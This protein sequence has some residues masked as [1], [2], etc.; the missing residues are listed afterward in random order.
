MDVTAVLDSTKCFHCGQACADDTLWLQGRPFCCYG[1]KTVFEILDSNNLCEYYRLD[2]NPGVQL[3]EISDD[4]YAH[5]DE[6]DIRKRILTFDSAQFAKVSF[7]VP[8]IHC[9]SC[10]WL[11]ENLRKLNAGILHAEVNFSRKTVRVDFNPQRIKLSGVAQLMAS[12]GYAPKI[13]LKEAEDAKHKIDNTLILKVAIAGFCFGN[14]MLFSFPEYLG[15]DHAEKDLIRMFSWLNLALAVPALF[16]CG[17]DYLKSA[18]KSF[19]QKQINIDAPIAA[20]FIALFFRSAY[21]IVTA[22]GPGYLDSFTGL[23]FFLLIG[24]WFQSRTYESLAF[25][26]DFT[27]YFPLAVNRLEKD[28]WKP[29]VI[30]KLRPNDQIRIRNMELVP[31]DSI[32]LN[33]YAYIDYSFVT[34]ESRPVKVKQSEVAYAG[35]RLIGAPVTLIVEKSTSQSHLTSLWNNDAFRKI[36][37]SNYQKIIDRAA[38]KFTWFVLGIALITGIYWQV[39]APASMWLVLTS[40]LMVACPCAL[41]LAAPFTLGSM[42][43]VMGKNQLYL[44]NADV[45]ER[46]ASIDTIIFDKT[47]TITHGNDPEI[48]WTGEFREADLDGI[49]RLTSFSTHPLSLM[50]TRCIGRK[51][52]LLVTDFKELPGKGIHG[53]IDNRAFK[54]GSAAFAGFPEQINDVASHV[55]VSIDGKCCGYFTIKTAIRNNFREMLT[56]LGNKCHGLLSGDHDKDKAEMKYIFPPAAQLLFEQ[57]PQQKLDYIRHLQQQGRKV[58]MI[59]DGLNDAGALKQ[60]DVGIAVTDDTGIFTPAC[61]GILLGNKITALDRLLR[62]AKTSSIILKTGFTISFFYNAIALGFAVTGSLSPLVAAII[63]PISSISVVGFSTLAVKFAASK[64]KI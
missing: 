15:I 42:L 36:D 11:L 49:K 52:A 57:S 48:S 56:R 1:C 23:V 62:F 26:R 38:Q 14:V 9:I 12:V 19:R 2:K 24:R 60:S 35:G 53:V 7:F 20:G 4:T 63:M 64:I 55:Y 17:I 5:L 59:G 44:K 34:G 27:A 61:D 13:T 28:G 25:D 37:E 6:S 39:T 21:D 41:A 33:E 31:A 3:K 43:R 10:I 8:S 16:Y 58:M 18:L 51:S 47:G 40:V 54:I 22:T 30:Y 50:I 46:M 32:L 29:I 45:I